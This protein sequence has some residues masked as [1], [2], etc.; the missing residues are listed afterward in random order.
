M[1]DNWIYY[2]AALALIILAAWVIKKV[3]GCL[4][5]TLVF[6]VA[7]AALCAGYWFWVSAS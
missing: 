6:L 4:L 5:K 2:V 1:M 7:L 3:A